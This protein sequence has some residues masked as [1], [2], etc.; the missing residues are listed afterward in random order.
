LDDLA[1]GCNIERGKLGR[2]LRHLAMKHLF[3]ESELLLPL[4]EVHLSKRESLVAPDVWTNNRLSLQLR[5]LVPMS[6]MVG[7]LYWHL[8]R[9]QSPSLTTL[10]GRMK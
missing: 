8:N 7:H 2:V 5:S 3:R 1:Q 4:Q 10:I 9:L 6:A